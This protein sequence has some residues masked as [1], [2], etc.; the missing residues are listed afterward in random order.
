MKNKLMK[1]FVPVFAVS[2]CLICLLAIH[3]PVYA[4]SLI[5][6][7]D[8]KISPSNLSICEELSATRAA[9]TIYESETNNTSATANR[10][11]D[12]Y[13]NYGRIS[14]TSDIDW[15]VIKFSQNGYAS[16]WLDNIPSG[17]DYDMRLYASDGSSILKVSVKAGNS[18]ELIESYWVSANTDYYVRIHSYSGFS[19][20]SYYHLRAKNSPYH[21]YAG[22]IKG[23]SNKGVSAEIKMPSS[24]PDVS[25]S[26]E[27]VWVSTSMDS[28]GE[29][30]QAGARYYSSFTNFKTYTEHYSNGIYKLT[31]HGIHIL[32]K[33]V[34]YKVEYNSSDGKWHAYISGTDMVSSSLATVDNSVQGNAEVHKKEIEMGPFTFSNVKIKNSSGTWVNN[35]VTPSAT[36]PYSVTGTAT[37]FTVSG[38]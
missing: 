23:G 8:Q 27:S 4:T 18:E 5:D 19:T 10:T 6:K 12:D 25:D 11:Y 9:G 38:P 22:F 32:G 17:C 13:D 20:S 26:G 3:F 34:T 35:T 21:Q 2:L 30:I 7:D 33:V 31:T 37:N 15:W 1:K 16:F 29:W 24:L 14:T 28:N 36:S